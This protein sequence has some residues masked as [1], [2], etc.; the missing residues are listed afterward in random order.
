MQRPQVNVE[1][2]RRGGVIA[3]KEKDM[4]SLWVKTSCCNLNSRQLRKLADITDKYGRGIVLFSTR[5]IPIIPFILLKDVEAAKKELAEV[6]M[7][8][9]R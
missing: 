4:F 5:Q 6:E 7:E 1:E 9:D 8:L 2:L 3:L